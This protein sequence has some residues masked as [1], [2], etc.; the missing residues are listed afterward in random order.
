MKR[1]TKIGLTKWISTALQLTGCAIVALKLPFSGFA[2]P[3][4]LVG[5]LGWMAVGLIARD[6]PLVVLNLA[7][8]ATNILGIVR[9]LG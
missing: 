2:F 7:Y 5:S 8:S 6:R 3:I 4:M 1:I 9:W